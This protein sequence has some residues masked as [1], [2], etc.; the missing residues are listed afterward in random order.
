MEKPI[1]DW[2]QI[3]NS[4][5]PNKEPYKIRE[6]RP[7]FDDIEI[8]NLDPSMR[9]SVMSDLLEAGEARA[10]EALARYTETGLD[11]AKSEKDIKKEEQIQYFSR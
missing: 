3:T 10:Q 6:K 1:T 9:S 4:S 2:N 11:N 8:E 7:V 5:K